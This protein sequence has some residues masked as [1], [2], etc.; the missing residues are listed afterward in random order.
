MAKQAIDE[1]RAAAIEFVQECGRVAEAHF[2]TVTADFK[3]D[4]SPVSKADHEAQDAVVSL[5]AG[6]Y[7]DHAVIA[8]E[9][10]GRPERH[11]AA[12]EARF[13]W[14]IDP[15]DGTR[16]YCRGLP[17]YASSA[18]LLERGAP[19]A[20]AIYD[21]SSRIVFS[22]ARGGG[23]WCGPRPLAPTD[24]SA[25]KRLN[26]AIG[27]SHRKS[28]LATVKAWADRYAV[29]NYGS[30]CLHFAWVASGMLDAAYAAECKLWDVAA[31]A[32]LIEEA[33]GIV[34]DPVGRA[35]W[36]MDLG[37]Y[38]GQDVPILAGQPAAHAQ[39]LADLSAPA[40]E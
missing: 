17:L 1:F 23:A 27:S 25:E 28:V 13:C 35:L 20:C 14:V 29:R 18:A 22:A 15:I 6:R 9:L 7:G 21:A 39:L 12:G 24:G 34:S 16:N 38:S 3:S 10:L 33:G 2:G 37:G 19:V 11:A 26:V 5:I 36:P 8:E 4:G 40:G 31:G 32:L 30:V